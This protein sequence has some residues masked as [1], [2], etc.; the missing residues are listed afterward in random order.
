MPDSGRRDPAD[1]AELYRRLPVQPTDRWWVE[2]AAASPDGRVLEFGAGTGRLTAALLAAGVSVIAVERDP[3]MLRVLREGIGRSADVEVVAGDVTVLPDGPPAGLVALPAA[4]LNELPDAAARRAVL[5]VAARH[6][7]PQGTVAVHL[8]SP[9]WLVRL[10]G[11][12]VGRLAT[13]GASE[14]EVAVEAGDLDPWAARR[15]AT[16]SYRFGDG[17]VLHD[18]LDAAIVTPFELEAALMGAG[19]TLD[20]VYGADPPA[21]ITDA[22]VAWHLLARP[23]ESSGRGV[24][25]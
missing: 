9:W 21:P 1:R 25:C 24:A 10:Q 17:A 22:D 5:D 8:L 15:R 12:G 20:A 4:L 6:C 11:R 7:H 3:D 16:L 19:L 13:D 23:R 2:Q 18:H 14:T